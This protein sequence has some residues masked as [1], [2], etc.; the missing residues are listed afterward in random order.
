M[1]G[2]WP[3]SRK[4]FAKFYSEEDAASAV[5]SL[6]SLLNDK[7]AGIASLGTSRL[8]IDRSYGAKFT[9]LCSM[10]D[11]LKPTVDQ[12]L[13]Q[14]GGGGGG[15][16]GGEG[17][18]GGEKAA[19]T[20]VHHRIY[21]LRS[22]PSSALLKP[23][24]T[25]SLQG[26]KPKAIAQVKSKLEH[27]FAGQV[28]YALGGEGGEEA[29]EGERFWH[30]RFAHKASDAYLRKSKRQRASL[31][32]ETSARKSYDCTANRRLRLRKPKCCCETL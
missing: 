11:A 30:E 8:L 3:I 32:Y 10:Y 27:L 6:S 21:D 7:A 4:A 14:R 9:V 5:T 22:D 18:G 31:C 12:I 19:G 15:G 25:I 1:T 17:G 16:E 13:L 20:E 24:V 28:L 26:T 2:V 23:T 29:Q